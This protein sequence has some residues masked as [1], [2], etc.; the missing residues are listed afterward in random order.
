LHL[1]DGDRVIPT[2]AQTSRLVLPARLSWEAPM[3]SFSILA[4]PARSGYGALMR[5]PVDRVTDEL[6]HARGLAYDVDYSGVR[7]DENSGL[8]AV[9]ADGRYDRHATVAEGMWKELQTMVEAGPLPE[10]LEHDRAGLEESLADSRQVV[11]RPQYNAWR[12]LS[13]Q[14]LEHPDTVR[15][16]LAALTSEHLRELADQALPTMLA[17]PPEGCA[18]S[19]DGLPDRTDDVDRDLPVNGR[20]FGRRLVSTAPPRLQVIAGDD[21]ITLRLDESISTVLWEQGVGLVTCP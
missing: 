18:A 7:L 2:Q 4:G 10:E 9:W 5:I 1:P 3:T 14:E 19:L 17:H 11:D 20:P 16:E 15:S 12:L 21:G 13:G 6:R 8:V